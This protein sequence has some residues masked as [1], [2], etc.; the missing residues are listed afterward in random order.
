VF[1]KVP[2][3]EGV[4]DPKWILPSEHGSP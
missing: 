3:R 4:G 1:R 2:R